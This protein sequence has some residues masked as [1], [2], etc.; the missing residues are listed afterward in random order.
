MDKMAKAARILAALDECGLEVW[1]DVE[2]LRLGPSVA[3]PDHL[4]ASIRDS[5]PELLRL[6]DRRTH[7][8]GR[9]LSS[10]QT[11]LW[12]LQRIDPLSAAYNLSYSMSLEAN[13]SAERWND[14]LERVVVRH[15][16]LRSTFGERDGEPRSWPTADTPSLEFIRVEDEAAAVRAAADRAAK[17]FVMEEGPP[18]SVL[19]I[20]YQET[21]KVVWVV[22]HLLADLSSLAILGRALLDEVTGDS[23]EHGVD[24]RFFSY[25]HENRVWLRSDEAQRSRAFWKRKFERPVPPLDLFAAPRP[26]KQSF[27]GGAHH[28]RVSPELTNAIRRAARAANVTP[29]A[30]V[31]SAYCALLHRLG[32]VEDLVVGV[33]AS[34]ARRHGS[35]EVGSFANAVPVRVQ[36]ESSTPF[37]E[38]VSCVVESTTE[39]LDHQRFPFVEVVECV[40]PPRDPSRSPLFQVMYTWGDARKQAGAGAR[41]DRELSRQQGAPTD[42]FLVVQAEDDE[43][44]LTWTFATE[45]VSADA[46]AAMDEQLRGIIE[47]VIE[48]PALRLGELP[49]ATARD[50]RWWAELNATNVAKPRGETIVSAFERQVRANPTETALVE[51][52]SPTTYGELDASSLCW[53]KALKAMGIGRGDRVGLCLRG[54]STL[55]RA[56]LAVLRV[57]AAYVPIDPDLP[58]RRRR[59]IGSDAELSLVI[60]EGPEVGSLLECGVEVV[61]PFELDERQSPD[62]ELIGPTPADLAYLIY[63]S[64]STGRPKGVMV[65]HANVDNLFVGLDERIGTGPGNRWLAVTT[66]S[67]DIS[68]LELLWT[69]CRGATVVL[70]PPQ[71]TRSIRGTRQ[72]ARSD[73]GPLRWSLFYFATESSEPSAQATDPYALLRAGA[74]FA[75]DSGFDAVWVPERHFHEFGGA[76][77]NPSLIAASLASTTKNIQL[78]AGSV[79]LPLHDPIRVAEEWAVVDRLSNGRAGIAFASGWQVD[80]FVL[81]P[82]QYAARRQNL[83]ARVDIVRRLWRGESISRTN[84]VGESVEVSAH[85]RPSNPIPLWLTAAGSRDTFERAGQNGF[86]VLTH[87]LGQNLEEL[88]QKLELYR[89]AS[90]AS[91]HGDGHVTLMLHTFIGDSAETAETYFEEPFKD[92]LRSSAGL[93]KQLAASSG[94]DLERNQALVVDKAYE[95]YRAGS[96]LLGTVSNRLEMLSSLYANG[97]DEVACLVDF[98]IPHDVVVGGFQR[99]KKLKEASARF[100]TAPASSKASDS[101]LEEL[102]T[103]EKITHLQVTPSLARMLISSDRG[104]AAMCGIDTLLVGGDTLSESLSDELHKLDGPKV[105]NMYGPTEATVWSGVETCRG[106]EGRVGPPLANQRFY[107]IDRAGALAPTGVPGELCIAGDGVAVGYFRRPKLTAERFL[108][109]INFPKRRMY[110]TGDQ[111]RVRF[112]GKI[113]F[114][115]RNDHQVKVRGHRIELGE[116]ERTLE[117]LPDVEQS[118]VVAV[119][120]VDGERELCAFVVNTEGDLDVPS[121]RGHLLAQLPGAMVPPRIIPLEEFPLTFN[122]KIDRLSLARRAVELRRSP[123]LSDAPKSG[124]EAELASIWKDLLHIDSIPPGANF[125][126]IGGHSVMA[127]KMAAEIERR[128]LG[129]VE[130]VDIFSHP[131]LEA[132][133]LEVGRDAAK[134]SVSQPRG[135]GRRAQRQRAALQAHKRRRRAR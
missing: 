71:G 110:R 131:T 89:E 122:H 32:D 114:L 7:E 87:L 132:L 61:A 97:V 36:P 111:V 113:D 130:L 63:T 121:A 68:V 46:V 102:I 5:K 3:V 29:S 15:P 22:H 60:G 133:S 66:V 42:L 30:L 100:V 95:R 16:I 40:N 77:P 52:G 17:P 74:A 24:D 124:M 86:R 50:Q 41:V 67:F 90:R 59:L 83:L 127:A 107:V 11:A 54:R 88:A 27:V 20:Q 128:G 91:G 31:L 112:D 13:A 72:R 18:W 58:N 103:E 35:R 55:V 118:A 69:L 123:F 53:A 56:I 120:T 78:R 108:P 109:E 19:V 126:E 134:A 62:L 4:I 75:D 33:P 84:G 23:F 51:G 43:L 99:L 96:T 21:Q 39:A 115:G 117:M 81:A 28:S 116:I 94:L 70:A 105:F 57:G 92:Y 64:G 65:S 80:D 44:W 12:L 73:R 38:F 98:G 101:T 47:A 1:R 82:D 14:A 45:V 6:L 79:V 125:F 25:V 76:Y 106:E 85:P 49:I 119:D 104:R 37:S 135:D 10:G 48:N 9:P 129:R 26:Q 93:M 8:Q 34:G 2:S